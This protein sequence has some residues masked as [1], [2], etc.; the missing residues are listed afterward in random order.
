[1]LRLKRNRDTLST[2]CLSAPGEEGGLQKGTW[3][4]LTPDS[5]ARVHLYI[6]ACTP[7]RVCS[8]PLRGATF[9]TCRGTRRPDI[10][11][12]MGLGEDGEAAPAD[13]LP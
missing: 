5:E 12:A 6:G 8:R 7:A 13:F 3:A 4:L 10:T 2:L 11:E 9:G 1:M